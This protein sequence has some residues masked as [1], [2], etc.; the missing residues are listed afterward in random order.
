MLHREFKERAGR[1]DDHTG[2][3]GPSC[4]ATSIGAL[5]AIVTA[6]NSFVTNR[7]PG[8]SVLRIWSRPFQHSKMVVSPG[9]LVALRLSGR[10][11]QPIVD[12]W[13]RIDGLY[14]GSETKPLLQ[15]LTMTCRCSRG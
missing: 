8:H 12:A 1:T 9:L 14:L 5:V 10:K 13:L 15:R 4:A 3:P 2:G 7:R 11:D 6:T